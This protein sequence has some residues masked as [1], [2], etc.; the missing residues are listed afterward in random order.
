MN[1]ALTIE[2]SAPFMAMA[3]ASVVAAINRKPGVR[4]NPCAAARTSCI[5]PPI[6]DLRRQ[7]RQVAPTARLVRSGDRNWYVACCATC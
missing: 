4:V 3:T 1:T 5:K 6:H 7:Y 2:K